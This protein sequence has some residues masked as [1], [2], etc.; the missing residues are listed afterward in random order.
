M[1]PLPFD[2]TAHS[3][4]A[5]PLRQAAFVRAELIRRLFADSGRSRYAPLV[6]W[7]VLAAIYWRQVDLLELAPL[8][9]LHIAVS[10]AF[11]RLQSRFERARPADG[12]VPRWGWWFTLLS[13]AAGACWGAAGYLL[14]STDYELQ[15][16]LLS[17][18]L[19]AA[20]TTA[21]PL[22]SAYPPAFHAL[23]LATSAPL[24]FVLLASGDPFYQLVGI[25]GGA[26]VAHLISHV[27]D[28]HRWQSDNIALACEK[29][30]LAREAESANQAKSRFLATVSHEI[31]TPMNGVLGMI[32][33]LE[34]SELKADQR[35]Q[36]ATVRS[37]AAALLGII[38]DIL[39]FSKIEAGRLDLEHLE[40]STV[41][42]IE[43]VAETLAPQANAK[44]LVLAA[45]VAADAPRRVIGDPLRL[46]QILFNLLGNAI[47]FTETG[48]VTVSLEAAGPSRLR[49]KVV[50]TGIG[51][52]PAEQ[53]RLFQPFVQAD[54][55]TTRRFGG[56]GLGL[57]IV[58]R[59][60]EAMQGGVEVASAPGR[61]SS[62]EVTVHAETAPVAAARAQPAAEGPLQ[63]LA[64]TVSLPEPPEEAAIARY[65]EE[66]GAK[67]TTVA[68]A[69]VGSLRLVGLD[70]EVPL[71]A[72]PWRRTALIR[73]VA[74]VAGRAFDERLPL[75]PPPVFAGRVLVVDDN[76]VNRR[77]LARQLELAG[78][79]A[80]AAAGGEEALQRWASAG[81]DLVLADLQMPGMD[82]FELARRIRAGEAAERRPRTPI[83]AV[84]ASTLEEQEQESRAAGMDGFLA[85]PVAS[86]ELRAA[87][88]V[89]LKSAA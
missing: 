58:R 29:E 32:D 74:R 48:S 67:V 82:G 31:R 43:S 19:L 68:R 34:R 11:D 80:D 61:G 78:A 87:L 57:S 69:G 52:S 37:S 6:L 20:V 79:E 65:L 27:R 38:D 77:I 8:V 12:D 5:L 56:T 63:G 75:P 50:D 70:R 13:L 83:L 64:L 21:V 85:K 62:F 72:R 18:V 24:L 45:F 41:E 1:S 25:A 59:L 44:G 55:S 46:R 39:D 71:P 33:V 88:S 9:A 14:A 4:V 28:V 42:L 60:A 66:A 35:E 53:A 81:Y 76:P 30:D 26:Y 7:P 22:R 15:R 89:W 23:A 17:L 47:K 51:L 40:L 16:M 10:L 3:A 2:P 54:S 86:E 49:L 84:T 36:L 73:A